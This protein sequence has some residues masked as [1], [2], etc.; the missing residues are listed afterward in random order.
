[1]ITNNKNRFS[2]DFRV[3]TSVLSCR[4]PVDMKADLIKL[5]SLHQTTVSTIV[6]TLIKEE[7]KRS[8]WN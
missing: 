3:D 7:L 4:I 6:Y 8:N 1:M 5:A 2:N